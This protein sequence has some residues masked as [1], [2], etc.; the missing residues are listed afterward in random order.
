MSGARDLTHTDDAGH[1]HMV[2]VGGKAITRR[3]A[4]ARGC[5]RTSE[6]ALRAVLENRAGK[7]DVLAAARIAGIAAAKRTAELIPLCHPVPLDTVRVEI[8]PLSGEAGEGAASTGSGAGPGFEV[9]AEALASHRTGVEMEAFTAVAG[10]LLTLYDMLKAV[11]RGMEIGAVHLVLKEGG[12]SG[13]WKRG[14]SDE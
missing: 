8:T 13:T 5:I 2:D 9:R 1:V 10:A 14:E 7:G 4:V 11:D 12:R 6:E 3:R